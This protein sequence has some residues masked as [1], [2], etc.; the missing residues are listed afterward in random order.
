MLGV[1]V[2]RDALLLNVHGG[3]HTLYCALLRCASKK[4][5]FTS[6]ATCSAACVNATIETH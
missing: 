2:L 5:R 1:A 6:V 3:V 4:Q